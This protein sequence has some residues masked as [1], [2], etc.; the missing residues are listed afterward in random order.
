[1]VQKK[2]CYCFN[3]TLQDIQNDYHMHG[4]STIMARI[5]DEKKDGNCNCELINPQGR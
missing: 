5:I 3:Y 4:T 1:M 2:I